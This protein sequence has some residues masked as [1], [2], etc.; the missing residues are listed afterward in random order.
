MIKDVV[1][2][3]PRAPGKHVFSK[4]KLPRLGL[5]I[6]GALLQREL[7]ISS[8]VYFQEVSKLDWDKILGAD[9]VGISTITSTAPEAFKLLERIKRES[10]IPVVMGGPHVTFLPEEALREGVDF[11]V[12]GE[13]EQTFLELIKHLS[14][15]NGDYSDIDGLSYSEGGVFHHNDDRSRMDDLSS[16]PWPDLSLIEDF[17]K[18]RVVPMITSRGCP[19]NCKFCSVTPMFGHRYRYRDSEDV[20]AELEML[21]KKNPKAVF[22]FYDDNFTAST[23]RAKELL[24]KM[25]ERGI[26]PRWTAQAT[27]HVVQDEE[28]MQLMKDTGCLFLYLGLESANPETLKSYRKAQTVEDIVRAVEVIHKYKIKVHGMFVLGSDEDDRAAIRETVRFA[29]RTGIDT[30]QFLIL[31]PLPGTE[32]YTEMCQQGRIIVDDWSKFSGHHVVF[33]PKLISPF[34]LQKEGTVRAMGKFYSIWQCWKLGLLFRWKDMAIRIYAHRTIAK[35]KARNRE[36]TAELKSRYKEE[37]TRLKSR[38]KEE[39]EPLKSRYKGE[40]ARLKGKGEKS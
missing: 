26:T 34:R 33:N 14:N 38:Y 20:L 6:L 22:F 12:R 28:L 23:S 7:G 3:E 16:L 37:K 5:P 24:Q 27:V 29:K 9:L 11:V 19:H 32:F 8:R 2:I 35:W 1:L 40:K 18:V 15:G 36:F 30:V 10:D 25:K 13:G 4:F 21:Y 39:K 31:T 17:E